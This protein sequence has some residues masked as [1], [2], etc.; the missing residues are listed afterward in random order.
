MG[1]DR[2]NFFGADHVSV[3]GRKTPCTLN[4]AQKLLP[5]VVN[6]RL[7]Q[8]LRVIPRKKTSRMRGVTL[9][10]TPDAGLRD[11]LFRKRLLG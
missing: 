11:C 1:T 2:L 9:S 7:G 10:R 8:I 3:C 4:R 6:A 5:I